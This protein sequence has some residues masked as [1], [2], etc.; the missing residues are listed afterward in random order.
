MVSARCR[1]TW[2]T[3]LAAY[4]AVV[5]GCDIAPTTAPAVE[6]RPVVHAV[7]NP[8]ST[9]Q[10]IIVE[11][12]LS[13][14]TSGAGTRPYE[15][16]ANARVVIY[17]PRDDSAVAAVAPGGDPGRYRVQSITV[18]DGS[19]GNAG[20]NTLRLRP[21][22]RYRLRVDTPLGVASGATTIPVSTTVDVARR[23]F[24]V[25]RDTLTLNTA[26]VRNAAGYLLRHETR[27]SVREQYTNA[28]GRTL[29]LPLAQAQGDPEKQEWAFSF[30]RDLVYPG[31]SENFIVVALDSNYFKY[32]AAGSDPFGD[33]TRGNSLTGG[34]GMFG[35]V[36]TIM[37]KTLDLT[38]NIDSPIEG[39]WTANTFSSTM[40]STLTLYASPFFPGT[41]A[42]GETPISGTSR[43]ASG[44]TL[45]AIGVVSGS[46]VGLRFVD[47][48]DSSGS[49]ETN[50]SITGTA[51]VLTNLQ[52]GERTTY[53]KR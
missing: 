52:T 50:G 32:Y 9:V 35:A 10:I 43:S 2:A 5:A 37:S 39:T 53:S 27:F 46:N 19:F 28:V 34:V 25:D 47:A 14:I 30:A 42:A 6:Q 24:N 20:P 15:P 13:A 51:L 21:G 36:A 45:D 29:L 41:S 23:T 44:R 48:T 16:I 17:G 31:F 12:T 18:T 49:L 33:D 11:R 22:E 3:G 38:A 40:P 1:L 7:L 4:C 26:A 8:A